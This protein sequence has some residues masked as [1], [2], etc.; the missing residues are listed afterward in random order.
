MNDGTYRVGS[1]DGPLIKDYGGSV[2]QGGTIVA[3]D[4]FNGALAVVF[5]GGHLWYV[6][7]NWTKAQVGPQGR[8]TENLTIPQLANYF[9]NDNPPLFFD[10]DEFVTQPSCHRAS[11][12]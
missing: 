9:Y 5:E 11:S 7:S 1:L 3:A 12:R 8:D 2:W 10:N 4:K 6:N